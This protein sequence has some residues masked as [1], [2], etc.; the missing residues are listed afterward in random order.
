MVQVDKTWQ[1]AEIIT[2]NTC[3]VNKVYLQQFY[4]SFYLGSYEVVQ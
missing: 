3:T 1:Q 4:F 2:Y